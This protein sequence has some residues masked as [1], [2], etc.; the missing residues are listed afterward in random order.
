MRSEVRKPQ[1][2]LGKTSTDSDRSISHCP[3]RTSRS[4]PDA[5]SQSAYLTAPAIFVGPDRSPSRLRMTRI[6]S[7]KPQ[8]RLFELRGQVR[9]SQGSASGNRFRCEYTCIVPEEL[10]E[11]AATLSIDRRQANIVA[12]QRWHNAAGYTSNLT[13]SA[14][15]RQAANSRRR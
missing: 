4:W 5:D 10:P 2:A 11:A 15:L 14:F 9:Q 7:G 8:H 12:T 13:D 1:W 3:S 6:R